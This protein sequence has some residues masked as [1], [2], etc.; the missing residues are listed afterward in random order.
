[1]FFPPLDLA[2][3]LMTVMALLVTLIMFYFEESLSKRVAEA[4]LPVGDEDEIQICQQSF[5]K[6]SDARDQDSKVT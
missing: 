2:K 3:S 5:Q 6:R 1:M 4:T